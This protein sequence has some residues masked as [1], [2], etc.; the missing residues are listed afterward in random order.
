MVRFQDSTVQLYLTT[1][2]MKTCGTGTYTVS[3]QTV[4]FGSGGSTATVA[5]TST[6]LKVTTTVAGGAPY[7]DMP[8]D[9]A[10]YTRL[11][12]FDASAF[13]ACQ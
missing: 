6:T 4:T 5:V 2:A 12:S 8:G 3:G 10:D 9:V 1:G 13:G 11:A 7:F